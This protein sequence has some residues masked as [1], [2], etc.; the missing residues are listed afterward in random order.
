M[1]NQ[2]DDQSLIAQLDPGRV[3][4][5]IAALPDQ[6]TQSLEQFRDFALPEDY[7]QVSRIVVNGMGG[8]N[9]GA[10]LIQAAFKDDLRVP[11]LLEPGYQ[12]PAYVDDTTLYIISSYS[13]TTEEP[14]STLA[15][16]RKRGAKILAVTAENKDNPLLEL[17]RE[18]DFPVLAFRPDHNPCGQP[19]LGVGYSIFAIMG[20]L[21]AAGLIRLDTDQVAETAE[22]LRQKNKLWGPEKKEDDNPAKGLA[23]DIAG[24]APVLVAAEFLAGNLHVLR[25]QICET[26]KNFASY[27]ELPDLNHF[28]MEGLGHPESNE[29]DMVFVFFE[30]L[31]YTGRLQRRL[32]LTKEVVNKNGL[33]SLSYSLE[34]ET[35]LGQ[36]LEFLQFGA[37][38]SYYLGLANGI[39]PVKIPWVDWFKD[40]LK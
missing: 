23:L 8:S 39:D 12:V 28:A 2:L 5:S 25:N 7:S 32:D 10:H 3:G 18:Q 29:K 1:A 35:K 15:E 33:N 17:A 22:W 24:A 4:D 13:G 11:L 30:S 21:S 20:S 19:R 36:A 38:I 40:N 31:L 14:L 26:S 27:L 34:A 37:W 9:L 16:A 6:I